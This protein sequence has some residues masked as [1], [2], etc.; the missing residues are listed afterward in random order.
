MTKPF[1]ELHIISYSLFSLFHCFILCLH[2]P[3]FLAPRQVLQ[4]IRDHRACPVTPCRAK[5][6]TVR[7]TA[8][9]CAQSVSAIHLSFSHERLHCRV[10]T[11]S[12][13]SKRL[14]AS[15]SSCLTSI[16]NG[17]RKLQESNAA[18]HV[19]HFHPNHLNLAFP[20]LSN[21]SLFHLALHC[22]EVSLFCF[23]Q[24]PSFKL[25]ECLTNLKDPHTEL[26]KCACNILGHVVNA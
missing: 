1:S 2:L 10:F 7:K 26:S 25:H 24:P 21:L 6:A 22:L 15:R 23:C 20:A 9:L 14:M 11:A 4:L 13:A 19:T 3:A 18:L 16:R 5:I 8:C 17:L 12:W